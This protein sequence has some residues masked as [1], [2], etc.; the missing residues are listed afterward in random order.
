MKFK[1]PI[2]KKVVQSKSIIKYHLEWE[3]KR[4]LNGRYI[5]ISRNKLNSMTRKEL[6]KWLVDEYKAYKECGEF[7]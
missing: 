6:S 5:Y 7:T 2:C 1:C 3:C 4:R